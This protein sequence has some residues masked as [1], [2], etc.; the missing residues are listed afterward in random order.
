MNDRP[1]PDNDRL[2]EQPAAS[3]QATFDV[4]LASSA[5]QRDYSAMRAAFSGNNDLSFG[6]FP[7][8]NDIFS[9]QTF[10]QGN[11]HWQEH[12]TDDSQRA[13]KD[14]EGGAGR[15]AESQKNMMAGII[16]NLGHDDFA[17]REKASADLKAMLEKDPQAAIRDLTIALK[18]SEVDNPGQ[19]GK[20]KLADL[21][22]NDP[23]IKVR[24]S[25]ALEPHLPPIPER[26]RSVS[27]LVDQ[28]RKWPFDFAGK[29]SMTD[30]DLKSIADLGKLT[31]E[32]AKSR[33]EMLNNL[34]DIISG[35]GLTRLED[36]RSRIGGQVADL[37]N[38]NEIQSQINQMQ[39]IAIVGQVTD[40]GLQHL[41]LFKNLRSLSLHSLATGAGLKALAGMDKLE[42]IKLRGGNLNDDGLKNLQQLKNLR[43][44]NLALTQITDSGLEHIKANTN[45]ERLN[46]SC[47]PI[48]DAGMKHLQ[49][50]KNLKYLNLS[51]SNIGNDG[52]KSLG[53]LKGLQTL[54]LSGTNI[55]DKGV[56][57]IKNLPDLRSLSLNNTEITDA[58]LEQIKSVTSLNRIELGGTKVSKPALDNLQKALPNARISVRD[59]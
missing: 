11:G 31:P 38:I 33:L 43:S 57:Q 49:D 12:G 27:T 1:L 6:Q 4:D 8:A 40:A 35:S 44:L 55:T 9:P 42:E 20:T 25:R 50:L 17:T 32:G 18:N 15:A 2:Q 54:D 28:L 23:E 26:E 51:K 19:G 21:V 59:D 14:A 39:T 7:K 30:Q 47:T 3:D 24:L 56:G 53:E 10:Q 29:P 13:V 45:L 16:A 37:E 22:K 41:T 58:A 52:L 34:N 36:G 48:S 46:L 5:A